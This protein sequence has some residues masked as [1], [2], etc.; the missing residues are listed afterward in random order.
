MYIINEQV[1]LVLLPDLNV[2]FLISFSCLT[3]LDSISSTM[4]NRTSERASFSC[5]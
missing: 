3:A 2:F 5:F 1:I 4:L